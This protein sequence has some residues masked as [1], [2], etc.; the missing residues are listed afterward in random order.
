LEGL[1]PADHLARLIWNALGLL[2]LLAFYQHLIVAPDGPGRAAADCKIL[3]ALW[4]YATSQGVTSARE[5]EQL[6]VEHLA[7]IWLCGG[8]TM[9]YHT[10]SD[11]RTE[12]IVALS[13]LLTELVG[14]LMAAGLVELEQVAQDGMRVRAS[15]GAASFRREPTLESALV[16]ARAFVTEIEAGEHQVSAASVASQAAQERAACERVERLEAE[17]QRCPPLGLRKRP[18]RKRTR[19]G[20]RLPIQRHTS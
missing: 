20:F 18:L 2:D 3:V 9:N 16:K 8:V 17:W 12:H 19:H 4:L 15:A 10:L 1:L 6:C 5:V 7:Y 13:D 14:R 11:F